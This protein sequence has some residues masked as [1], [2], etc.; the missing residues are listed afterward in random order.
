MKNRMKL[1]KRGFISSTIIITFVVLF[2]LLMIALL[3]K[4]INTRRNV[5]KSAED[6]KT[7]L[8][9]KVRGKDGHL[10]YTLIANKYENMIATAKRGG[11]A[12]CNPN[13]TNDIEYCV[14]QHKKD[15][16]EV[17][18]YKN[19]YM[20][21]TSP[22]Y[23]YWYKA[24]YNNVVFADKCWKILRTTET[25]G[26]KL[27]YMGPVNP[28]GTCK[29]VTDSIGYGG[30]AIKYNTSANSENYVGY[31][32]NSSGVLVNSN[33]K[34]KIDNFLTTVVKPYNYFLEDTV[35]CNDRNVVS[36]NGGSAKDYAAK[37]RFGTIN[38]AVETM[39]V[40]ISDPNVNYADV[41][42]TMT[43]LTG[44]SGA[45]QRDETVE[46][47]VG[48]SAN[49]LCTAGWKQIASG[50][51]AN[52]YVCSQYLQYQSS[53]PDEHQPAQE[54]LYCSQM[55]DSYTVGEIVNY[56]RGNQQLSSVGVSGATI[57]ADEVFLIYNNAMTVS[58]KN[59]LSDYI[60]KYWTMTPVEYNS[61]AKMYVVDDMGKLVVSPVNQSYGVRPAI[62][63][64]YNTYVYD[65]VNG[66]K[67]DGSKEKP[68]HI[69]TDLTRY[70]TVQI[71]DD[72]FYANGDNGY[73]TGLRVYYD[74][75]GQKTLELD[76]QLKSGQTVTLFNNPTTETTSAEFEMTINWIEGSITG[77]APKLRLEYGSSS[78]NIDL[79]A[80]GSKTVKFNG[81]PKKITITNTSWVFNNYKVNIEI[82][83]TN[84]YIYERYDQGWYKINSL[85]QYEEIFNIESDLAPSAETTWLLPTRFL[86]GY[87][88]KGYCSRRGGGNDYLVI[89]PNGDIKSGKTDEFSYDGA[90]YAWWDKDL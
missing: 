31:T 90:L 39:Y 62:A 86:S 74:E 60:G 30:E 22:I 21:Y 44:Y 3:E 87:T 83:R 26:V 71:H 38:D 20:N 80:T 32:Y 4:Y 9:A 52:N 82:T 69:I 12:Q 23:Y 13:A 48:S 24:D 43:D 57:T 36:Q 27:F 19:D 47:Y 41:Y 67:S 84:N 42:P 77:S 53:T 68:Y 5:Q 75:D 61:T 76:G 85:G 40:R 17:Y 73:T 37:K 28:D 11:Y 64:K 33:L 58:G 89:A 29:N 88:F 81:M 55:N 49:S 56:A 14:D 34:A 51:Y 1:N 79:P 66:I 2:L 6:I 63:L 15:T 7:E 70:I 45:L 25:G 59:Y 65:T 10:L 78:K 72:L 54:K 46:V 18:K 50:P 16:Y 35:W 8:N